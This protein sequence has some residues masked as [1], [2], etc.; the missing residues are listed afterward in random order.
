[1]SSVSEALL[2]LKN[3]HIQYGT[4]DPFYAV[5]DL[6]IEL[7]SGR[8]LGVAGESGCGKST[9]VQSILNLLPLSAFVSKGSC[10]FK[11]IDLFNCSKDILN[12]IRSKEIAMIFQNPMSALNPFKRIRDQIE[13][14]Y[15][16]HSE[17]SKEEYQN[18]ILKLFK[19]VQFTDPE[20]VLKAYPHELSGG[21]CQR[22]MIAMA[23]SQKPKILIADE[24]TTAL[25]VN[26]QK[27]ILKI[28]KQLQ[29]ENDMG[30][31][32][33]T[34]DL[35]VLEVIAD[36]VAVMYAGEIVEKK[37]SSIFF[38]SPEHPY[39]AALLKA[40]PRLN[41]D[42]LKSIPTIEGH[43][44]KLKAIDQFCNFRNR[45]KEKKEICE[46]KHIETRFTNKGEVRC[47][48]IEENC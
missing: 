3:V 45:C 47:L 19:R 41:G 6:N 34:H 2:S 11:E 4:K 13:E 38:K 21:M 46:K 48:L 29:V 44:P 8:C 1:M 40:S 22:I 37:E 25:D 15:Q 30:V 31:I 12:K 18:D 5:N 43:P 23:V 27:E 33:I 39:S 20:R 14:I 36:E 28:I 17:M 16:L 10:H 26:T 7:L 24:P 32:F 9:F 35:S 42:L